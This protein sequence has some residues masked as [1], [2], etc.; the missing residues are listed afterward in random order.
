M[1]LLLP[2][3]AVVHFLREGHKRSADAR[4]QKLDLIGTGEH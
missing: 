4:A 2:G 3:A 1:Q